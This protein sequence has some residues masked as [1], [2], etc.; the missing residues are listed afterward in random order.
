VR[1]KIFNQRLIDPDQFFNQD[2]DRD[3]NLKI[4][5]RL[6]NKNRGSISKWKTGSDFGT[7]TGS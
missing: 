3:Y 2:H 6:K 4:G 1:L 7:K 5:L